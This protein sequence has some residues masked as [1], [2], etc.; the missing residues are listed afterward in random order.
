MYVGREFEHEELK[1]TINGRFF[2][3]PVLK[4]DKAGG[5]GTSQ[6]SALVAKSRK[7]SIL[8]TRRVY[9]S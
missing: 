1:R 9:T 2:G 4:L 6:V 8:A 3:G 5:G 7:T